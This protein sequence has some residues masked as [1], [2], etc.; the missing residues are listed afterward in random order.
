MGS[1]RPAAL[2]DGVLA[3]VSARSVTVTTRI[4]GHV[5][6]LN[7][8]APSRPA[9]MPVPPR[10]RLAT[11]MRLRTGIAHGFPTLTATF[12]ARYPARRGVSEYVLEVAPLTR[13]AGCTTGD[14]IDDSTIGDVRAGR[15]VALSG[16]APNC[17]GRWRVT[18]FYAVPNGA[19]RYP[20]SWPQGM[21]TA[22]TAPKGSGEQ[23]VATRVVAVPPTS[24]PTGGVGRGRRTS[25][26]G[27]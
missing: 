19:V 9:R 26:S 5:T 24:G 16:G 27:G 7:V 1:A 3:F 10:S 14:A 6:K 2:R 25:R 23:I 18:V 12:R 4:G 21:G 17:A 15:L 22:T 13:P 11:T 20:G 8:P